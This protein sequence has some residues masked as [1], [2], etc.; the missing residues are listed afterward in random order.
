VKFPGVAV[1]CPCN[2]LTKAPHPCSK[3]LTVPDTVEPTCAKE[4]VFS[5][6]VLSFQIPLTSLQALADAVTTLGGVMSGVV[7]GVITIGGV[8]VVVPAKTL[9]PIA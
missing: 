5:Y 1:A 9:K 3:V 2:V 7:V 8:P 4:Y 6:I